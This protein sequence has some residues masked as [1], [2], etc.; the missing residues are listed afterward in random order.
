MHLGSV[1]LLVREYDEAIAYY[2]G[3]L[4]FQLLEDTDLGQGKRWVRVAPAG[5]ATSLL[6][7]QARSPEQ[8]QAIGN[9]SGGRVFLFLHADDFWADYHRLKTR[10]VQFVEEPRLESYGYVVVFTDLYG[11]AWDLLEATL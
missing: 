8:M 6:L 10:G 2:V 7:A 11:N 5:A 9:Q 3:T 1:A 4:G